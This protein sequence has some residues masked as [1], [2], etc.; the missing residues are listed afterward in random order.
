MELHGV[1]DE[2]EGLGTW[3]LTHYSYKVKGFPQAPHATVAAIGISKSPLPRQCLPRSGGTSIPVVLGTWALV[4]TGESQ[5]LML[6]EAVI[7][8]RH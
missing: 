2:Q 4:M 6:W 7:K 1:F 5:S 3:S 8:D